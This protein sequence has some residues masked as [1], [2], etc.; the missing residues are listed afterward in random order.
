MTN[1]PE[2]LC[3]LSMVT[4]SSFMYISALFILVHT[5]N[6]GFEHNDRVRALLPLSAL[7]GL[8]PF[9]T[10]FFKLW[11]IN[12]IIS[13]SINFV[14]IMIFL[15]NTALLAAYLNFGIKSKKMY[16]QKSLL[17]PKKKKDLAMHIVVLSIIFLF[18]PIL[19]LIL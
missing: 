14:L 4:T 1:N 7:A 19:F 17:N 5:Y 8:P 9:P 12:F 18:T 15:L 6:D 13:N 11:S 10:F 16:Q 2:L 3:K